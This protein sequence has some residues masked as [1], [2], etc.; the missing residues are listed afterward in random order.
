[1]KKPAFLTLLLAFILLTAAGNN[2][3]AQA[4]RVSFLE[5][6]AW[7]SS[8]VGPPPPKEYRLDSG[9]VL[10]PG[11]VLRTEAGARVELQISGMGILRLG[12]SSVM[13]VPPTQTDGGDSASHAQATLI[14][15]D[16]WANGRPGNH[17]APIGIATASCLVET[18]GGVFRVTI[19]PDHSLEVKDYGGIIRVSEPEMPPPPGAGSSRSPA[20]AAAQPAAWKYELSLHTKIVVWPDGTATPP[21]RF[22]AKAD[23]T[24]WVQW[25]LQRDNTAKGTP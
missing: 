4:M 14:S 12:P 15:G 1:M 20:S 5:G 16:L 23:E 7:I 2:A 17:P 24:A 18:T 13:R 21:F 22:V 25:N 3:R 10:Q 8:T 11:Q 19:Y 9:Q 6:K